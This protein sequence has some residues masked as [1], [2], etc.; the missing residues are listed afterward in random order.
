MARKQKFSIA[1]AALA[2]CLAAI[3]GARAN[4]P[5]KTPIKSAEQLPHSLSLVSL[6]PSNTELLLD[7]GAVKS[8]RGICSNC[9]KVLPDGARRLNGVPV[10][11]TFV[12][13]NLERLTGLKPDVV[14]LVSGQE[15]MASMLKSRK[16]NV[17]MVNNDKVAN[18]A[19]NLRQLGKL[20]HTADKANKLADNFDQAV[21][22]LSAIIGSSTQKQKVF[23]CVWPQPLLTVGE[24]SFLHDIITRCGGINIAGNLSQPYPQFSAERLVLADPDLVI[25]PYEAKAFPIFSRFPW[26][27]L[28]AV[29]NHRLFYLPPPKDDMLSR[30]TLSALKGMYWLSVKIHPEL[31]QQLDGWQSKYC[32]DSSALNQVD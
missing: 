29:K 2:I 5:I 6:A 27:K 17:V 7:T 13:V 14:L 21:K 9:Q 4:T 25:L 30:P 22:K 32:G 28:R 3:L 20:S 19:N 26:N 24:K 16:F 11:G 8:I 31:K 23:Y 10:T 1:L 12:N 18:I 15:A